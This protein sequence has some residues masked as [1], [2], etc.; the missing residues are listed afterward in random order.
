MTI[1]REKKSLSGG[2]A[3]GI[4]YNNIRKNISFPTHYYVGTAITIII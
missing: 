1:D 2:S 3:H 4:Y